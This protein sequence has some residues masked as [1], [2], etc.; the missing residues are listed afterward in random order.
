MREQVVVKILNLR[1]YL[2]HSALVWQIRNS[3]KIKL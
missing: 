3:P 2:M 1:F